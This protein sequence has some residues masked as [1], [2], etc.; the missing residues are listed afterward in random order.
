[1]FWWFSKTVVVISNVLI[2][3]LYG[4]IHYFEY[5]FKFEGRMTRR[6]DCNKNSHSI[7]GVLRPLY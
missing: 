6:F 5:S 3:T 1:M 2:S 4:Y 7:K